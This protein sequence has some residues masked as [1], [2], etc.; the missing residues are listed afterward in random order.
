MAW[1]IELT[2]AAVKALGRIDRPDAR[3]ILRFLHERIAAAS[4]PRQLGKPLRG[5]LR[6][7]WR[8]RVGAFRIVCHIEDERLC[9]LVV[10]VAHRKA[11]YR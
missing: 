11:V 6:T 8:Y 1:R 5:E 4:D 3:R 10:R 7:Y 2:D 9:V